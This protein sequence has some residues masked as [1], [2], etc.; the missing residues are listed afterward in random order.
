[1]ATSY[2]SFPKM[3]FFVLVISIIILII[4]RDEYIEKLQ[5][6][7][8]PAD[9]LQQDVAVPVQV[10]AP[11]F[12]ST[13]LSG[14]M[15]GNYIFSNDAAD[16]SRKKNDGIIHGAVL[17]PD[18]FDMPYSALEFNG[19][20]SYVLL[21]TSYDMQSIDSGLTVLCWINA[22]ENI[23]DHGIIGRGGH[24]GLALRQQRLIGNIFGYPQYNEEVISRQVI[25]KDKWY[26]I[27]LTFNGKAIRIYINGKLA[28]KKNTQYSKIGSKVYQW[29][30]EPRIGA[31]FGGF[32]YYYSG[33]IDDVVIYNRALNSTEIEALFAMESFSGLE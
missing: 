1:M 32:N 8:L 7:K 16:Q 25:S 33:K 27:G 18:R 6:G 28:G 4:R 20:D 15:I 23:A 5:N 29:T 22:T 17:S 12:E 9:S 13:D 14:G 31:S 24:W 10:D 26:F 21:P 2:K 30:R 19:T 3:V 11:V